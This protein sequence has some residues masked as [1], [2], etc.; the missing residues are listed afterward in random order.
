MFPQHYQIQTKLQ[1]PEKAI[2][3]ENTYE[4]R[5]LLLR[6]SFDL[7]LHAHEIQLK[8]WLI[9]VHKIIAYPAQWDVV[10]RFLTVYDETS[11]TAK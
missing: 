4:T 8:F 6:W 7:L 1:S 10:H 2:K 9:Y 3:R 11:P 5:P